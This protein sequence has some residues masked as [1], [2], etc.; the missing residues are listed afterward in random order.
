M[1]YNANFKTNASAAA[2]TETTLTDA[3][4]DFINNAQKKST[5]EIAEFIKACP[6]INIQSSVDVDGIDGDAG[7]NCLV[8]L[9][10]AALRAVLYSMLRKQL[11]QQKAI[12]AL[13]QQNMQQAEAIYLLVDK[14][15]K[16]ESETCPFDFS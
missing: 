11:E 14:N 5:R 4:Q 1:S 13:T 2:A 15:R 7:V 9:D 12:N 16:S 8:S 6:L 10:A 3:R